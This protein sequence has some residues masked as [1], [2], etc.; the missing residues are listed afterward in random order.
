MFQFLVLITV[1]L[2][3]IAAVQLS[4]TYQLTAKLRNNREEDIS[5]ADN[6]MNAWLMLLFGIAFFISTIYLY[7]VYGNYF[8]EN[9]DFLPTAASAHGQAYDDLLNLNFVIITI[10]FFIVQGLLFF[11]AWKYVYDKNRKAE[12]FSH[13]TKL[14][15]IWTIA[16]TIVL[17]YIIV[18]GL[19]TWNEITGATT[20]ED[21]IRLEV[22]SKQFDWTMRYPGADGE[23][24][25]SNYNLITGQNPLGIVTESLIEAKITELDGEIVTVKEKLEEQGSYLP[26]AEVDE[27]EDKIYRLERHKLRLRDL[28]VSKEVASNEVGKGMDDRIVKGELHLP[29]NKE[30]EFVFNSRDVI[31]SAYFP[32]FR[33]QM[34][35]VP[36]QPTRFKMTPTITS[37]EMKLKLD[38]EKF[39]YILLC[40]KVCGASHNNMAVKVIIESEE[41]Y[42]AWLAAQKTFAEIIGGD[43]D[44]TAENKIKK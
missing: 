33:A 5:D 7:V 21:P 12:F 20:T 42:A 25:L 13:S 32:H 27:L 38:D 35:T 14:E 30:V 1:V 22:Y 17:A 41:D 29:V 4:K 3:V 11:F 43:E 37:E 8:G 9:G 28:A 44:P 24:G 31:H 39:D 18:Q 40:N 10:V 26:P 23:L 34:N 15:L 2:G 16:P 36:G 19:I 6:K